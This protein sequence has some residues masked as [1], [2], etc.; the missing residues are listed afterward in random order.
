VYLIARMC[1]HV[2]NVP[3]CETHRVFGFVD[4]FI[5]CLNYK[6]LSAPV[7]TQKIFGRHKRLVIFF[8]GGGGC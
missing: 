8:L 6:N 2:K 3:K 5:K 4:E 7:K 1:Y